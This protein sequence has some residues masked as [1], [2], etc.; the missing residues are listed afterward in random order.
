MR[1][2][3]RR[4]ARIVLRLRHQIAGLLAGVGIVQRCFIDVAR[5]HPPLAAFFDKHNGMMFL[6]AVATEES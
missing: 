1:R 2:F 4:G 3:Q 5:Q 6:A